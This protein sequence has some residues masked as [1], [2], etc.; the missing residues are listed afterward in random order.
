MITFC[1]SSVN[2]QTVSNHSLHYKYVC[3]CFVRQANL[4]RTCSLKTNR[5]YSWR[6]SVS[7]QHALRLWHSATTCF[8]R[9]MFSVYFLRDNPNVV[10]CLTR[11]LLNLST[12]R[13]DDWHQESPNEPEPASKVF[14]WLVTVVLYLFHNVYFSRDLIILYINHQR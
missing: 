3:I 11:A 14:H 7:L 12:N 1:Q 4:S 10:N 5:A 9:G 2:L 13:C 8:S 6:N